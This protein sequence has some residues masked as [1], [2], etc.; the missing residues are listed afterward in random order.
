MAVITIQ[1]WLDKKCP[2][3][4]NVEKIEWGASGD[5]ITDGELEIK[6]FPK[7]EKIRLK[8]AKVVTKLTISNCPNIKVLNLYE[9]KIAEIEGLEDLKELKELNI[10]KNQL[11]KEIK[12]SDECQLETFICFESGKI[13]NDL[14][15]TRSL[16]KLHNLRLFNGGQIETGGNKTP[17]ERS[18]NLPF[19]ELEVYVET[20]DKMGVGSSE[21]PQDHPTSFRG[22]INIKADSMKRASD[23]LKKLFNIDLNDTDNKDENPSNPTDFVFH[24]E[25]KINKI[26][27]D[28][29]NL[30]KIN[31]EI[32]KIEAKQELQGLI[33]TD[34]VGKKEV[35]ESVLNEIINR[36]N[37]SAV[38]QV[39]VDKYKSKL[40]GLGIA[41][42]GESA[43]DSWENEL[44]NKSQLATEL[45]QA[46][47][48]LLKFFSDQLGLDLAVDNISKEQI[49][50]KIKEKRPD[51]S[52]CTHTDYD[53]IR[54]ERD[55][56]QTE[57]EN[58]KRKISELEDEN[59]KAITKKVL[60]EKTNTSWDD[61]GVKVSSGKQEQIKNA[62]S[63]VQVEEIRGEIIKSEFNRL[64]EENNSSFSLNLVLGILLLA[65]LLILAWVIIQKQVKGLEAGLKQKQKE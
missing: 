36:L 17:K 44:I 19:Q 12:F 2:N 50:E 57:M 62:A 10:A 48:D 4:D 20:L 53:T 42:G 32:D 22:E 25:K 58:K 54:S 60:V 61:W 31:R 59:E 45:S 37:A 23:H 14:I 52:A 1:E 7:L 5:T 35:D 63:A 16:L 49:L 33:K 43:N 26:K 40:R 38:A 21:D 15:K 46:E 11:Q 27:D 39:S 13:G 18:T 6:D 24:W 29:E 65:N 41:N 34:S 30:A 51:G 55:S 8:G 3:K 9:N 64:K 47:K 28:L 56:L